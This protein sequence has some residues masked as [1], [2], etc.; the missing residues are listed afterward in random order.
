VA[1][2]PPAGDGAAPSNA[3]AATL[4]ETARQLIKE[5]AP[6][7]AL[8]PL[9]RAAALEPSHAEIGRLLGEARRAEVEHLTSSA[10]N[11]FLMNEYPKAK[12][13]VDKALTLDPANKKAQELVK[14]LGA[15]P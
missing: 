2:P 14:I 9:Q 1:T 6:R 3:E 7:K 10:L 11:H 12:K 15:L 5:R 13:A 4:L 8:E